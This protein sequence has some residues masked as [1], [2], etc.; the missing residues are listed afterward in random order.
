VLTITGVYDD[1]Q[2]GAL[3]YHDEHIAAVKP[4][5]GRR[6]QVVIGPWDHMGT[7]TAARSFGG[8]TFA[9]SSEI[10]LL[11]L[12]S[13]WFDWVLGRA[14]KPEI[15]PDRVVY[16]HSGEDTWRSAPDI[17]AGPAR[18]RLYPLADG[19]LE[20]TEP[21]SAQT[22]ELIADP[23]NAADESLPAAVDL[24]GRF[25]ARLVLAADV[26]D[27]DLLLGVYRMHA[28]GKTTLLGEALFRA[29][30]RTS[31]RAATPWPMDAVPGV[32]RLVQ[33][34][35]RPSYLDFPLG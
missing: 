18:L 33:D 26:P 1:D 9:E 4:D 21:A 34:P 28:D 31:L 19:R 23:R 16:F 5:V 7:R 35:D 29:R 30:H 2:L 14:G 20:T 10:D 24:S 12:Q 8:L 13:D 6:H 25:V 22:V 27:F 32:I 3:R 15:L 17:P 11:A